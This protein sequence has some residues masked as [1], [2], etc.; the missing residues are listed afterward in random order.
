M[1]YW[2]TG[3]SSNDIYADVYSDFFELYN[4][5]LEI[6]EITNRLASDYWEIVEDKVEC[7]NFWFA[8]AKAQWECKALDKKVLDKV[9]EAVL[10]GSNLS[11]WAA[12]GASPKDIVKRKQVLEKFLVGL[13]IEKSK[14]SSR[15]KKVILEPAF[16]KGE[17]ITFQFSNGFFGAAVI[18]EAISGICPLNLIAVLKI[19]QPE[20]PK[21]E[22]YLNAEIVIFNYGNWKEKE[23]V[24]WLSLTKEIKAVAK[25]CFKICELNINE[26]YENLM[27]SY[28]HIGAFNLWI[29]QATERQYKWEE[30]NA[31]PVRKLY[32]RDLLNNKF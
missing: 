25:S 20:Q 10:S 28:G 9:S 24:H 3:I 23:S 30:N 14:P 1:G 4:D 7:D 6:S 22:D 32:L 13:Q 16:K 8:I 29:I 15:K 31:A 19:N 5:G 11:V 2:G 26:A 12:N 27:Y 18:L 21:Y 17:C